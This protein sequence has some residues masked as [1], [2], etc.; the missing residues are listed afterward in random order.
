[1]FGCFFRAQA[2]RSQ[3]DTTASFDAIAQAEEQYRS[4]LVN[5]LNRCLN[6]TNNRLS[7]NRSDAQWF[8]PDNSNSTTFDAPS[9]HNSNT[10]FVPQDARPVANAESQPS[11]SPDVLMYE[12]FSNVSSSSSSN[13]ESNTVRD[14][15]QASGLTSFPTTNNSAIGTQTTRHQSGSS[16]CPYYRR[17]SMSS[18]HNP[19]N[20][21]HSNLQNGNPY[22]RPAYAPH[23]SL[24]YRQHNNQE[25]HRRHM[26]NTMSGT[27]ATNEPAPTNSFS[28]PISR[29]TT[30]MSNNAFC[31]QCDQQHP[32]GHPHR[33]IR[34][35]VCGL[36][37]VCMR[38]KRII[39]VRY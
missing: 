30:S 20:H 28:Y 34:Q 33:R 6:H 17:L 23:E 5:R 3:N 12:P 16:R 36:N 11:I 32:V 7:L 19:P 8:R 18:Y 10:S 22:L 15:P 21:Y 13:L 25:I 4:G 14:A 39:F 37:L 24:W 35:Y 9:A 2:G 1:M 31:L 26:T 29:G 27:N 38:K